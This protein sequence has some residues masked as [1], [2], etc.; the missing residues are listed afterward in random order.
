M[1]GFSWA[2][3]AGV[4]VGNVGSARWI[5]GHAGCGAVL[6]GMIAAVATAVMLYVYYKVTK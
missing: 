4:F 6:I 1:N 3:V 2:L 5:G